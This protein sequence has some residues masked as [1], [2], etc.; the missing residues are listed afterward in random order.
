MEP[1]AR[2]GLELAQRSEPG[3]HP[4]KQVNEDSCAS[5]DTPLGHLL[6]VCDGMG[7]HEGGA[8]ASQL[9][10]EAIGRVIGAAAADA[11]PGPTLRSAIEHAGRLVWEL[12][13]PAERAGR[14]GATCVAALVHGGGVEVAHVGDSRAYL[15]R[16][17]QVW[18]LT[19]DHS[20]VQAWI[21]AGQ[22]APE[23]AYGHPDA[24]KIT[25]ALGLRP[26]TQVELRAEPLVVYGGDVLVLASDGLCDL[27][28]PEEL[29]AVV[30]AAPTPAQACDEL[31]RLAYTRGAHDNVTVQVARVAA[32]AA[33]AGALA[34]NTLPLISPPTQADRVEVAPTWVDAPASGHP[35]A[36][37]PPPA[38]SARP[39]SA[40]SPSPRL[41][42]GLVVATVG[43]LL[44]AASLVSLM[45]RD[46]PPAAVP[47]AR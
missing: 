42:V 23:A 27:A 31:V 46:Q 34:R 6:V 19:R 47:A 16:G 15:V 11:P 29:L 40:T 2:P 1:H 12:G 26:D 38:P 22:M 24:N 3:L 35:V 28:R 4:D 14:P 37:S 7:G 10:V 9:A 39:P 25:R 36:S 32:A 44:A 13:G 18:P 21:D 43:L 30:L 33:P 17:G 41:V 20:L 8:A 5:I 45:R